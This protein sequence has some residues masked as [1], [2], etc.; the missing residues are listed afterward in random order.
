MAENFQ[1]FFSLILLLSIFFLPSFPKISDK[2]DLLGYPDQTFRVVMATFTVG[3]T[4]RCKTC[5]KIKPP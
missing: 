1:F 2:K 3:N 4:V 5:N